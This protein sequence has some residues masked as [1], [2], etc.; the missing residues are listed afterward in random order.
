MFPGFSKYEQSIDY[1]EYISDFSFLKSMSIIMVI[2]KIL[3]IDW[4][5]DGFLDLNAF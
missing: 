1:D 3:F 2:Y 5:Y 4:S